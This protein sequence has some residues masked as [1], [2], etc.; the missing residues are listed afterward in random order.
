MPG[1][2]GPRGAG[3]AASFSSR[4]RYA[5]FTHAMHAVY[6][7]MEAELD[8]A[9]PDAAAAGDNDANR[10]PHNDYRDTAAEHNHPG[11]TSLDGSRCRAAAA[12]RVGE[13]RALLADNVRMLERLQP[14]LEELTSRHE[15]C[16]WPAVLS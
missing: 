1:R 12:D 4:A 13:S 2:T 14:R 11:D 3:T 6:S 5:R 7:T 16:S 15:V 10:S 9:G 8:A